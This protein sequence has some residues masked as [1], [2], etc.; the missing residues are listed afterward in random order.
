[1]FSQ[2][3]PSDA[4][5]EIIRI[6]LEAVDVFF[7]RRLRGDPRDRGPEGPPRDPRPHGPQ[8]APVYGRSLPR[9]LPKG[10]K[11]RPVLLKRLPFGKKHQSLW[12]SR[13]F[14]TL[15]G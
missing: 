10:S 9:A 11:C 15:H 2:F 3:V 4:E 14:H 8:R 13:Y 1:M 6:I 7:D 12:W 5:C